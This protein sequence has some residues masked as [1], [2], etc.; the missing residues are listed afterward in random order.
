MKLKIINVKWSKPGSEGQSSYIF[1]HMWM[2]EWENKCIH[3]YTYDYLYTSNIYYLYNI[4][5]VNIIK[6]YHI[7]Y[8]FYAYIERTWF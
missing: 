4:L 1:L 3:K 2:L 8:I 7:I 5:L 6:L